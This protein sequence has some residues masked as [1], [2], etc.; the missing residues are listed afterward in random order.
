[1]R[2]TQT[3]V[4]GRRDVGGLQKGSRVPILMAQVLCGDAPGHPGAASRAITV[5]R[6]VWGFDKHRVPANIRYRILF[7]GVVSISAV[8]VY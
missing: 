2:G 5:G 8:C 4:R 6:E 7:G 3:A 1:M